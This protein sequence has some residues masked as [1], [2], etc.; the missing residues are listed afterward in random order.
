MEL[1]KTVK[2]L[3]FP[4]MRDVN[5]QMYVREQR[6]YLKER[7][8][9]FMLDNHRVCNVKFSDYVEA[10][11][12]GGIAEAFQRTRRNKYFSEDDCIVDYY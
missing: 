5:L 7:Y 11:I 1:E 3:Q 9:M 2:Q 4:F 6:T 10:A 12:N 8:D